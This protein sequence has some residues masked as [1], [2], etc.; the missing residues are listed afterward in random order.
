MVTGMT[1]YFGI[2]ASGQVRS[3]LAE[4]LP[5]STRTVTIT[6]PGV[7][8][9]GYLNAFIRIAPNVDA[10]A[11]NPGPLREVSRDAAIFVMPWWLLAIVVVGLGIW[12]FLRFRARRDEKNA[13]AW[14][15]YTEAEARRKAAEEAEEQTAAEKVAAT[16]TAVKKPASTEAVVT[17]SPSTKT[18]A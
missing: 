6:V 14:I 16:R 12:Q 13:A 18:P 9:L 11:L 15:E 7:A 3:E 1:T 8:Q 2:P 5:G 4:M 17:T 10:E